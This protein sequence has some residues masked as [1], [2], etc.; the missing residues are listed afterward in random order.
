MAKTTEKM[1]TRIVEE[2]QSI[3]ITEMLPFEELRAM[4]D[5]RLKLNQKSQKLKSILND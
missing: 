4:L 2:E 5:Q 3:K 1:L